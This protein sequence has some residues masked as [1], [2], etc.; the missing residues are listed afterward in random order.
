MKH[1]FIIAIAAFCLAGCARYQMPSFGSDSWRL[2]GN[3]V[4]NDNVGMKVDFGGKSTFPIAN[5]SN[6]SY[7]LNFIVDKDGFDRYNPACVSY[8]KDVLNKI[9]LTINTVDVILADQ[10]MI[11]TFSGGERWIPDYVRDADG[12]VFVTE[13]NPI[14]SGVQP[15]DE[16]WRN[17]LFDAKKRQIV[18]VDR[19]IKGGKRYA[20]VYVLQSEKK[21]VPFSITTQYNLFNIHNI[22]MVGTYL[23]SLLQISIDAL[24]TTP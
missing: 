22:E 8:I 14:S 2:Q 20:I 19:L 5:A 9:P 16:L 15:S 23:D 18:V 12:T 17:L 7:D 13:A 6:G 24:T 11:L 21:G 4:I 1:L 3:S 10:Y